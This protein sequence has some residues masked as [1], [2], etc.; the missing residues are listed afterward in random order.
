VYL[1]QAE[2]V[3]AN[4]LLVRDVFTSYRIGR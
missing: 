2:I 4:W 1:I 3:I